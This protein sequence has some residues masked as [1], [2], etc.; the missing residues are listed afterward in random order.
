MGKKTYDIHSMDNEELYGE[1]AYKL[2]FS[3]AIERK[4]LHDYEVFVVG[5]D[6][7]EIGDTIRERTIS[8]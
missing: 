1:V 2:T 4:L 3:E 5:V 8:T 6:D 7:T